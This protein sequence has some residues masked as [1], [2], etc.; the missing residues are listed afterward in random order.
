MDFSTSELCGTCSAIDFAALMWSRT[1]NNVLVGP[2]P[3]SLGTIEDIKNREYVCEL[4][5]LITTRLDWVIDPDV[6]QHPGDQCRLL[7]SKFEEEA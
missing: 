3:I 2:R 4:C 6:R 7:F 1:M 5:K